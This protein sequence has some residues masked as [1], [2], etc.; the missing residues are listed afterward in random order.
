MTVTSEAERIVELPRERAF[1]LFI[2]YPRWHQWMPRA[3]QPIAG[4]DRPLQQGD[5]LQVRIPPVKARLR[6]SRVRPGEE[7]CWTGGGPILHAAHS[8]YFED[9][10]DGRT[11]I[12]SVEPWEGPL[13]HIGP[14][15]RYIKKE[16]DRIGTAQLDAFLHFATPR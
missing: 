16:A 13:L 8:F 5:R 7:V 4:P 2:D 9:A 10:G 6:V 12:R 15:A 1:E 14:L 11:R 3:F